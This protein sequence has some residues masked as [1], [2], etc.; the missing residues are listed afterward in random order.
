MPAEGIRSIR[1]E[2]AMTIYSAAEAKPS[3]L[4]QL[5]PPGQLALDLSAVDEIDCAGLQLLALA[6]EEA[7]RAGGELYLAECSEAV[8]EA[9]ALGGLA[10]FFAT[11][12]EAGE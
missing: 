9:L 1:L 5:I 11:E 6:R 3:L 2:G 12:Q 10:S 7:R 4:D 8:H